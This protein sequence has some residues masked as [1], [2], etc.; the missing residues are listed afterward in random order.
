M[1]GHRTGIRELH[2]PR[3]AGH[4]RQPRGVRAARRSRLRELIEV[5]A[6]ELDPGRTAGPKQKMLA[7]KGRS[8]ETIGHS[9][10]HYKE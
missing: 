3:L 4:A 10:L 5:T 8:E 9:D 1:P 6:R 2:L 7:E